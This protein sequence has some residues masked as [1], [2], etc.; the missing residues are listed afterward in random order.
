MAALD[1]AAVS[2]QL[3][4]TKGDKSLP[5]DLEKLRGEISLEIAKRPAAH[6]DII[7]TSARNGAGIA[8]LRAVIAG[9][10]APK[11]QD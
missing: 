10:A 7:V 2:Y 6:P 1:D 11:P 8:E 3:V 4:L 5:G 9:L